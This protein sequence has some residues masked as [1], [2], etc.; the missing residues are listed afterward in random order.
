MTTENNNEK[1]LKVRKSTAAFTLGLIG[2]ILGVLGIMVGWIPLLGALGVPL[3]YIGMALCIIGFI[4]SVCMKFASVA[5]PILGFAICIL[6]YLIIAKIQLE[7]F[8]DLKEGIE[9]FDEVMTSA[10]EDLDYAFNGESDDDVPPTWEISEEIDP[11]DD[12]KTV[13]IRLESEDKQDSL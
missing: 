9:E 4:I 11:L 12:T 3:T 2:L 5:F 6:S 1:D 7:V 13:F 10:S 8:A